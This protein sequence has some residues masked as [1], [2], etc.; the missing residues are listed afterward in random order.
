[1]N[2][3]VFAQ[4]SPRK[5]VLRCAIPSIITMVFGSLYSIADGL[6]VGRFVGEDALAA[7]NLVMPVITIVF[8]FSNM[9]A[10]GSS[11]HI[12]IL[13]AEK[14]REGAS[15]VFSFSIVFILLL[16]CV[17]GV[18][19][20]GCADPFVRLL[21]PGATEQAIQCSIEYLRVYAVF[22]PLLLV[23]YA[24]DNYLRICSKENLSMVIGIATQILNVVLDIFLIAI[25]RQGV[26]AAALASCLSMAIG[27]LITLFLFLGKRLDLY[28]TTARISWQKFLRILANGS[29]EFFSNI[30]SSILSLVMNLVLLKYGGTTAVAAFS[31]VM[32][33]DSIVGMLIFGLCEAMQP[34]ISYCY[35]ARLIEKVKALFRCV[36]LG[37]ILFSLLSMLFMLLAGKHIAPLFVATENKELLT[38]SIDAMKIFSFSYLV[39]WADTCF[40]SFFTALERPARSLIVSLFGTLIFPILFLLLLSAKFGLNGVWLAPTVAGFASG[41]LTLCLAATLKLKR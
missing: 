19:G 16:S 5:L 12:S 21:A 34:A 26:R 17:L 23:F 37:A 29:S 20:F 33:V 38:V 24:T 35:G 31:V 13:L 14:D 7:I 9:I 18:L 32:Y 36:L 41:M 39:G 1:M 15:Q 22:A 30:A 2:S 3:E 4:L 8:A 11:V 6:F 28:Y 25:L 10:T 27:S 40:S